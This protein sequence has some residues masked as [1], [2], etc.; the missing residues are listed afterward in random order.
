MSRTGS[1]ASA[2][3]GKVLRLVELHDRAHLDAPHS[4]GWDPG[5]H[6]NGVVQV[7]R[8]DHVKPAQLLLR[9]GERSVGGGELAVADPDRRGGLHGLQ[10]F[11]GQIVAALLD[12]FGE[13][14]V[15]PHE[16]VGL[17]LR[18]GAHLLLVVVDQAQVPHGFLRKRGRE[19]WTPSSRSGVGEIDNPAPRR[20]S[21]WPHVIYSAG[22]RSTRYSLCTRPLEKVRVAT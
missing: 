2:L 7:P 10:R 19:S 6:L 21:R 18:H 15:G 12:V 5:G 17:A 11:S 20:L 22:V 1:A 13:G 4:R 16:R 9:F 14:E 8:V 3:T